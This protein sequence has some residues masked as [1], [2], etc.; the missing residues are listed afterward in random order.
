MNLPHRCCVSDAQ[1]QWGY[2]PSSLCVPRTSRRRSQAPLT[3]QRVVYLDGVR[4]DIVFTFFARMHPPQADTDTV[5]SA[6][7]AVDQI[8]HLTPRSPTGASPNCGRRCPTARS[9][10]S[11]AAGAGPRSHAVYAGCRVSKHGRN[12]SGCV[13]RTKSIRLLAVTGVTVYEFARATNHT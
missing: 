8:L 12:G 10:T 7:F 1:Y 13:S 2:K 9:R 6:T 4:A 3:V 5:G 11:P